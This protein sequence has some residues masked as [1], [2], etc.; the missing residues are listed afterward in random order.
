MSTSKKKATSKGKVK[1]KD[2]SAKKSPKGGTLV[3]SF[4]KVSPVSGI[5]NKYGMLNPQPLPP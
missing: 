4:D 2:L 3:S 5:A 1:F